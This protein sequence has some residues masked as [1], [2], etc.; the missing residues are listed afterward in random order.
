MAP[1]AENPDLV[2]ARR[3]LRG[4]DYSKDEIEALYKS[5][6]KDEKFG[7]ARKVLRLLREEAPNDLKFCQDHAFC[8]YNDTDLSADV[9]Y[10]Q[11][12]DILQEVENIATTRN[13]ETLGLLGSI[14][15]RKWLFD[16]QATNLQRSLI[17]YKRGYE[18]WENLVS[19]QKKHDDGYTAINTAYVLDLLAYTETV[20]ALKIDAKAEFAQSQLEAASKIRRRVIA[21]FSQH[22]PGAATGDYW[23][24]VTLAEAHFGLYEFER[25]AELLREAKQI[26]GLSP[27]NFESTARQLASLAEIKINMFEIDEERL[28]AA[29]EAGM[30]EYNSEASGY[31]YGQSEA[32][33][34]RSYA[35][36]SEKEQYSYRHKVKMVEMRT[37]KEEM[38]QSARAAL[39]VF[40][41][42]D[43]A[44]DSAFIGKVGLAL[45]GGGFRA[46]LYHIGVLAKLA[47]LDILRHVEVLSCVSGGSIVG[48]FYYLKVLHL[49]ETKT[50][51]E[52]TREDYIELVKSVEKEFLA[53]V[54]K[55]IRARVF[56]SFMYNF[57]MVLTPSA[58]RTQR[59]AYLYEKFF[60]QPIWADIQKARAAREK[61]EASSSPANGQSAEAAFFAPPKVEGG[62]IRMRDL[63]IDPLLSEQEAAKGGFSFKLD[64]W[65]RRNKLPNLILNATALNTGHNWQFTASFMGEPPTGI[66]KEVDAKYLLRRMYYH[67]APG[68]F[69][70]ISLGEAVAASA[71][72]PALFEPLELEQLYPDITVQLVDGGV[73]DNQGVVGLM[74][75]ECQIFFVSDASGQVIT[76]DNVGSATVGVAL[77]TNDVLQG[78]I[79][80]SQYL[81]LRSRRD[82]S[83]I[84]EMMFIHLKKDLG[85]D[86]KDWLYCE[87]PHDATEAAK[88]FYDRGVLTSYGIRKEIQ[89]RL[90]TVRT[91][92]DSFHEAEAYALMYSGYKM[93]EN[94]HEHTTSKYF[95]EDYPPVDWQ[96]LKIQPYNDSVEKSLQL[97]KVLDASSSLFFKVFKLNRNWNFWGMVI[98]GLISLVLVYVML[99]KWNDNA[100]QV[101]FGKIG[102]LIMGLLVPAIIGKVIMYVNNY[103]GSLRSI[104]YKLLIALFGG[105][106]SLG[107]RGFYNTKYL[108]LG[109]L[110]LHSKD[111]GKTKLFSGILLL[112]LGGLAWGFRS[113]ITDFLYGINEQV[114]AFSIDADQ[115]SWYAI[116]LPLIG[117]L[118]FFAY[119][120][121]K[122]GF[123]KK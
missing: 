75:Q 69:K 4:E 74:E 99:T 85:D 7:Y 26:E 79:R 111:D 25:A 98:L 123:K 43:T 1:K 73:H 121:Y 78:R 50:D 6:K 64:N 36:L 35:E 61:K 19:A 54:Q 91:D 83:L 94:E 115:I 84:K 110:P 80:E 104:L 62:S 29:C 97:E 17:Y 59:I 41:G 44:V 3:V 38:E 46:S 107:I 102:L 52:I 66:V 55:N 57:K 114:Q 100:Y 23:K 45:S 37:A 48:A 58:T 106:V 76:Q 103:R 63:L 22:P 117:G 53:A 109:A 86:P 113:T 65:R 8:T 27:W 119:F 21:Y 32:K 2:M 56:D 30:A 20:E 16:N 40:L 82:S 105:V 49:L 14:Y 39:S 5:L 108:E 67:E 11:A 90:S 116:V 13:Q 96:F 101:T 15:K 112:I 31:G 71:G 28:E 68:E 88:A 51:A 18:E 70:N 93:A 92:L 34:V 24:L 122:Y 72:V 95:K 120:L 10:E 87:D 81:D 89:R 77:R 12:I 118:G 47:E 42:E 9:K 60:Y 33:Y